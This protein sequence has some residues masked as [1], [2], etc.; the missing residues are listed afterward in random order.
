MSAPEEILAT[1]QWLDQ[2]VI[3]NGFGKWMDIKFSAAPAAPTLEDLILH[4]PLDDDDD[5]D[6]DDNDN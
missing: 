2:G 1:Q 6:E 5:E 3:W 4:V